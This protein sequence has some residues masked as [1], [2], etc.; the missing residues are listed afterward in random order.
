MLETLPDGA[1]LCGDAGFVGYEFARTVLA[2]G[3]GLLVRVGANV[4]LW[5]QLGD[6]R[7][8]MHTVYVWPDKAA[9]RREPPLAFRHVV[10]QG[11]RHPLHLIVRLLP[12]RRLSD[13]QAADVDRAR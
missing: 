4:T 12:G 1:L 8:S 11:P 7:E 6:V 9:A 2:S 3:R 5:K 10:V 13:R